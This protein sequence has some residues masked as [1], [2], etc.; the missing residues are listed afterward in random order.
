[1]HAVLEQKGVDWTSTDVIRIGYADEPSGNV[2]PWIVVKSDSVSYEV[3]IEAAFACR[4][5]LLDH[6]IIN[7]DVEMRESKATRFQ[8]RP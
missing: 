6:D 3:S 1:M 5:L 4:G 8:L 2:V 7:A